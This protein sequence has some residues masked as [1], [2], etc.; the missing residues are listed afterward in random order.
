MPDEAPAVEQ[1]QPTTPE[2]P[3]TDQ[4]TGDPEESFTDAFNPNDLPEEVRPVYEEA[5]KRLQGDY[6]RKTAEIS[7]ERQEAQE[8]RDFITAIQNDPAARDAWLQQE[9][10]Y[11]FEDEGAE[12]EYLDPEDE[13]R[14]R[15][16]QLEGHLTQ[17]QQSEL[18]ARQEDETTEF[19]AE[20]I[21]ALEKSQGDD[22]EFSP[23]ELAF[24]STYA[25]THP[26][27]NGAPD[28]KGAGAALNG[29]L[30][31]RKQQW[32]ES[33]KSPRRISQGAPGQKTVIPKDR[34]ERMAMAVEAME[35]AEASG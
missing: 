17:Q 9:F 24:I 2:A 29:M 25:H 35:E 28:V 13:L 5:Y 8:Y 19:V 3:E 11:E 18:A 16:E 7:Q 27:Q 22:F 12:E 30:D 15:V 1:D 33:K 6:S 34:D 4:P 31:Q 14:A 10:G 21:E 32:V 20:E 23:Q 26:Q